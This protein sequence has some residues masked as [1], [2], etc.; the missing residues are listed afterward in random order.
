MRAT[1]VVFF[2]SALIPLLAATTACSGT[3]TVQGECQEVFGSPICTWG[4]ADGAQV[5]EFG[6]TVPLSVVENAP[7]GGEMVFPPRPV[8]IVPLPEAVTAA[9]G[10]NHLG[11]NWEPH[12]HPPGLFLTPHFDF[13]FYT[14]AP[15]AVA[16]IDCQDVNKPA[17]LASAY[18]LPDIDIP[19]LGSLVGLCVPL[20]GMHSMPAS[21]VTVTDPFDASMLVGYYARELVFLEP[22][23]SRDRLLQTRSF[24]MDVPAV[25]DAS[26]GLAWPAK[27]EVTYDSSAR[28]YRFGFEG[29][30]SR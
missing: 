8:A 27:L 1:P 13:H 25:G 4:T 26:S 10:F 20:M 11:V 23:I 3:R 28:A 14:I 12:G 30:A 21:E 24:S 9:T 16:G 15:D 18:A 6:A 5:T 17:T 19:G 22:M 29:L 2:R 7:L